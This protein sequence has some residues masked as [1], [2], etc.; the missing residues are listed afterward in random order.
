M[1][2]HWHVLLLKY[3]LC[4]DDRSIRVIRV[5]VTGFLLMYLTCILYGQWLGWYGTRLMPTCV[6]GCGCVGII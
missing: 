4:V 6:L 5:W 2:F 1:A 3:F